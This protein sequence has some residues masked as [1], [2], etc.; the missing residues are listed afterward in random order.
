MENNIV[1]PNFY[2]APISYF[3]QWLN[4]KKVSL[5][6]FENFPKQTYRNRTIIQGP[7]GR[8]SL[9]IPINHCGV[10][11]F[12]D[13][14]ISYADNW[15]NIHWK[16]LKSSYQSSPYF[17]YYEDKLQSLFETKEKFLFDL[18]LKTLQWVSEVLKLNLDYE[19]TTEYLQTPDEI[20]L[21]NSF[22]AKKSSNFNNPEYIQV[23]SD[24]FEFMN[25]LSILDLICNFGPKLT[26]YIK[27]I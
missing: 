11:T 27:E 6:K 22:N 19:F 21:R 9:I 12:K 2:F 26:T 25:D 3:H 24:R 8:L 20:D 15:Q 23:F 16:S 5:E 10:R 14:E 4:A 18:N 13:I 7:N 1:L 17:E